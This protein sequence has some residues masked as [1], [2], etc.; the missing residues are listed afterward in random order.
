MNVLARNNVNVYGDPDAR[1][2]LFAHGFG[3]DQN[4][5]RFV[6]PAFAED[7]R[8]VLFDHVGAGGSDAR[9]FDRDRYV[10]AARL[11][12]RRRR[13]QPR[14]RPARHRVRRPFGQ[15]DDRRARRHRRAR[16][17]RRARPDRALAPLHRRRR[18]P[19]RVQ[20]GGHRRAAGIDGLQLPRLVERD[21]AG[22]HGQR[23]P[24]RARRG[25]DEQ[26]L[27]QRPGDR[28]AVR[29][30]DLPVGQPR[31]SRR[32]ARAEPRPAVLRRPDRARG[33]R[34]LRAPR[35]WPRARY[36]QLEATGHCP[37]LSAPQET[38]AAIRAFVDA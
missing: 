11:R 10:V 16:P 18:L 32:G 14:A 15:R 6:W 2:M 7:F 33:R 9:A 17:L 35:A 12:R 37:N 19:R 13:D 5:W 20:R 34:P 21:G 4:M 3:C 27:S 36:V 29:A 24:P 23:R 38:I 31:R 30:R 1:P 26:L 8:I 25:A 28:R 22:D